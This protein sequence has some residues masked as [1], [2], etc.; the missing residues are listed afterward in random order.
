[1]LIYL[2][3]AKPYSYGIFINL[4]TLGRGLSELN[5]VELFPDAD[6]DSLKCQI[7]GNKT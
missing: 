3:L 2:I 1:M 6:E 7:N 4:D 5:A